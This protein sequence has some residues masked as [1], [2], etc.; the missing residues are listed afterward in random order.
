MTYN[1]FVEQ[2]SIDLILFNT[3]HFINFKTKMI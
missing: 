2:N 3:K 1:N